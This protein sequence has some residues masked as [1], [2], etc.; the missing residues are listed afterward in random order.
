MRHVEQQPNGQYR[1]TVDEPT[2]ILLCDEQY[3]YGLIELEKGFA[4]NGKLVVLF[5]SLDE[6]YSYIYENGLIKYVESDTD[7]N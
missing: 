4:D 6:A 5:G 1:V 3:Y 7:I 2:V